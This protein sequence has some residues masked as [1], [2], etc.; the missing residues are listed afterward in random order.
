MWSVLIVSAMDPRLK[1]YNTILNW[2]LNMQLCGLYGMNEMNN[3]HKPCE[4]C[5]NV[6]DGIKERVGCLAI[7]FIF[8]TASFIIIRYIW[9]F[10]HEYFR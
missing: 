7:F 9:E 3:E 4:F 6:Y 2:K 8:A 5:Q 10:V 1:S